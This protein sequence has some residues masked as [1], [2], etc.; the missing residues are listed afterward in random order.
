MAFYRNLEKSDAST[1]SSDN[2]GLRQFLNRISVNPSILS[3]KS[4]IDY[5]TNEIGVTLFSF[6]LRRVEDL[7]LEAPLA[8]LGVDSLVAIELRN[9]FRQKLGIDVG[10]L[11]ILG[12]ASI[13][14]LGEQAA[15]CLVGKYSE[16]A[17]EDQ[18][19][20]GNSKYLN[21]KAP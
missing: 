2:E 11:E 5:I 8:S 14:H 17:S 6:M 19:D 20:P 9:W 4:G 1:G 13:C 7:A 15:S 21:K 10:V 16:A 18:F 12:S 3:S